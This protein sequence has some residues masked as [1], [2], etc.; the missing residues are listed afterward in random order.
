MQ[1]SVPRLQRRLQAI[2]LSSRGRPSVVRAVLH[3]THPLGLEE[4]AAI[5]AVRSAMASLVPEASVELCLEPGPEGRFKFW[6]DAIVE[7]TSGALFHGGTLPC[8]LPFNGRVGAPGGFRGI[9]N[10]AAAAA[11]EARDALATQLESGAAVGEHLCDQLILPASLAKGTSRLLVRDLSLHAKTAIHMAE[12]L[13]PGVQIR[14]QPL[15]ALTLVEIDGVGL[16]VPNEEPEAPEPVALLEQPAVPP[17]EDAQQEPLPASAAA[18]A[19]TGEEQEYL[20][21]NSLFQ[22]NTKGCAMRERKHTNAK[23]VGGCPWGSTVRGVSEGGGWIKVGHGK[24]MPLELDGVRVLTLCGDNSVRAASAPSSAGTT[25]AEAAA[26]T[27]TPRQLEEPLVP[28]PAPAAQSSSQ[29]LQATPPPTQSAPM[30][31]E[32]LEGDDDAAVLR[33][34]PGSLTRAAPEL[35]QDFRRDMGELAEMANLKVEI[36]ELG[37]RLVLRGP[38]QQRQEAKADLDEVLEFYFPKK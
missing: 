20:V 11:N 5:E 10:L 36:D 34:P 19:T 8:D 24:F 14:Q 18:A 15:G 1:L 25:V 29:Q 37:N 26:A 3:A 7:T 6:I 32:P 12:L 23:V 31:L 38:P 13:A 21:D 17:A 30:E 22:A 28:T 35:L 4:D 9:A 33:L 16:A 27:A 2:D